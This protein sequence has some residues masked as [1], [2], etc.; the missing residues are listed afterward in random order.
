[1]LTWL[2]IGLK[3]G[4]WF[5]AGDRKLT[6]TQIAYIVEILEYNFRILNDIEINQ[7]QTKVRKDAILNCIMDRIKT[8]EEIINK[9]LKNN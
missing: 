3:A 5:P 4:D 2:A 8:R 1:M 7:E 9:I 6:E